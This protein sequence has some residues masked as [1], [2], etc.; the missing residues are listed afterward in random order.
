MLNPPPYRDHITVLTKICAWEITFLGF[1]NQDQLLSGKGSSPTSIYLVE[2]E[3]RVVEI[4]LQDGPKEWQ[5]GWPRWVATPASTTLY[6][7]K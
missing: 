4:D 7:N 1:P 3:V 2:G 6:E 5:R